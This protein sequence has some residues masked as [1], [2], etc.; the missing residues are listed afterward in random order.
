MY[1]TDRRIAPDGALSMVEVT[2]GNWT[3]TITDTGWPTAVPS[4]L[5]PPR[6]CFIALIRHCKSSSWFPY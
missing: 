3:L 2:A 4:A 1:V 5:P 6:P